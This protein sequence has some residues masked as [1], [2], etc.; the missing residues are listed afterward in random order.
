MTRAELDLIQRV[1]AQRQ[2][3]KAAHLAFLAHSCNIPAD[4]LENAR[5][6][7][8]AQLTEAVRANT[9]RN[10]GVPSEHTRKLVIGKMREFE[11]QGVNAA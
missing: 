2:A 10:L 6:H 1:I 7:E 4:A 5:E 3:E 11:R 9:G 8:W